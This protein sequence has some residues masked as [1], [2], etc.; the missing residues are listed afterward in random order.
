M[1]VSVSVSVSE[2]V[3]VCV[4]VCQSVLFVRWFASLFVRGMSRYVR[5]S[6]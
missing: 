6:V 2:C 3:R 1:S 5:F 4:F